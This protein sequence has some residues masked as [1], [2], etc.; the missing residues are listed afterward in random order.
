MSDK[1]TYLTYL[2]E[3]LYVLV[4]LVRITVDGSQTVFIFLPGAIDVC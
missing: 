1:L 3:I 2:A 4:G